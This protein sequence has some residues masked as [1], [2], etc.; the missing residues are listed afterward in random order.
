MQKNLLIF[1]T[2][3]PEEGKVKT[4]LW[5]SIWAKK[6]SDIQA[7]FIKKILK[8][9]Y[10]NKN[11]DFKV[12]LK[13]KENIKLFSSY[14][15]LDK[16]NIFSQLWEGLGDIMDNA[17]KY[18]L[19]DYKRVIIIGSDIPLL[20]QRDFK[21][22]FDILRERDTV[23]WKA[24]DWWYYLIWMKKNNKDLFK[25]IVYSTNTVFDETIEKISNNNLTYLLLDEKIDIDT[26]DDLILASK[27]DKTWFLTEILEQ[28]EIKYQ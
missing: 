1:L 28:C 27:Q 3:F 16:N 19:K 2:K 6:A 25:D 4:R 24:N 23:I 17:I 8:N 13:W 11:Y 15:W 18:W 14:F 20:D 7:L 12:W 21:H 9:N 22:W 10:S 26:L 5:K